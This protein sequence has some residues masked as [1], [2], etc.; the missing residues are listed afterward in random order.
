MET[1]E[2]RGN[3][4]RAA[5]IATEGL[6]LAD[7]NDTPAVAWNIDVL[8]R[9]LAA[10]GH[11]LPAT[12]LWGAA[13]V[14]RERTGLTLSGYWIAATDEAIA[15][16]RELLHDDHAFGNAWNDGR[17]MGSADAIALARSHDLT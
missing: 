9:T 12:R 13:E 4:V 16:T 11:L 6:Q 7:E 17:A 15:T 3:F 1:E 8:A 5:A 10:R 14:L 2:R